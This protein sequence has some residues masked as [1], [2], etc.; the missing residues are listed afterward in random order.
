MQ[1]QTL[2]KREPSVFKTYEQIIEKHGAIDV[3][4]LVNKGSF[5]MKSAYSKDV[6]IKNEYR[7][8]AEK[9]INTG[10][11]PEFLYYITISPNGGKALADR[12]VEQMDLINHTSFG[13]YK[14]YMEANG[15]D[16]SKF[17]ALSQSTLEQKANEMDDMITTFNIG[18]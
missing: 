6:L 18:G 10:R 15:I 4:D 2:E 11:V 17:T 3:N 1:E 12:I 9:I 13:D 16:I 14:N 7:A 5:A 8:L